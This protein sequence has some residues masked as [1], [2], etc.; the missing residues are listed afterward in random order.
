M[1]GVDVTVGVDLKFLIT[2][3]IGATMRAGDEK[4]SAVFTIGAV[5]DAYLN[6]KAAVGSSLEM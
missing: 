5:L 3:A 4:V 2:A 6:A 1:L